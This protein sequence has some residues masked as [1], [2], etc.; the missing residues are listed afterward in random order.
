[1]RVTRFAATALG[2]SLMFVALALVV[3]CGK[4]EEE[5]FDIGGA[6]GKGGGKKTPVAYGKAT[7]KGRVRLAGGRPNTAAATAELQEKM[8]TAVPADAG[9]C[10][11]PNADPIEKEQQTWRLGNDNGVG[12]VFVM[13]RPERNTFFA[14]DDQHDAI[15]AI[16]GEGMRVIDQPHCAFKPHVN[17]L[18]PEYLDKDGNKQTTGQ[19]LRVLNTS[20]VGHNTKWG[21]NT[22]RN[23]GSDVTIAARTGQIEIKDLK[24]STSPVILTCS[25]H[26]WMNAYVW[27]L[28]HPFVAVTDADGNYEIKNVPVGKVRVVAWHEQSGYVNEGGGKG[29]ELNL[30]EDGEAAK[31]F[32][33]PSGQ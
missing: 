10:L 27:V 9:T 24:P 13:L 32:S 3:G 28:D 33:V 21:D 22:P 5:E 7:L 30:P 1:M 15:K 11:N 25:V 16:K 29:E 18:V 14:L 12:N 31:D 4:K 2:L 17:Y 19:Y 23:P 26:K 20:P 8:R 6:G